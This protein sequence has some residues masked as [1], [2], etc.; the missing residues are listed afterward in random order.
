MRLPSPLTFFISLL[1]AFAACFIV[2]GILYNIPAVNDRLYPRVDKWLNDARELVAPAPQT[3]PTAA[4]VANLPTFAPDTPLPPPTLIPTSDYSTTRPPDYLTTRLPDYPTNTPIP[5]IFDLPANVNLPGARYEPQLYNNCG[6]ATLTAALV[7]WGWRGVEPDE[8]VWYAGG[9]DIRW[10]RDIAKVIKPGKSD[11][12]VMPYELTNFAAE[13]AGLNAALRYGG[14]IDRIRRFVANGFPVIIER[15]FREEEH[16]QVGQG[17]EGHYSVVTGYND[18]TR[19]LLT[20]DSF[21]G[22]NY[23]RD[24]DAMTRDWRDF[25]YLYF[26]LY[27]PDRAAQVMAL[28]GPDADAGANLNRALVKAQTQ[29][30]QNTELADLAFDWFNVGTSLQLL[31]RNTDAAIAFDQARSYDKLPYRMVW[32]QT[33]M[34]KAYFY[35]NR[36]QE[37][38]DLATVALQTPGLEESYYWRGWAY[39]ELGNLDAAI[40]DMRAAL[41]AHPKWDQALNA[42]REWGINP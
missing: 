30:S 31:G 8:L 28:L 7:Y 35:T 34:Y 17:W 10:Q 9:V 33:Y 21:K 18:T 32:Y 40:A 24:Y 13:Y 42:L 11:K 6:P 27:P 14:D 15:A 41:D 12:N 29:A 37:V 4:P 20:Q 5:L 3:L 39:H 36:Y 1:A 22:P 19:Q 25:N 16:G 26:I 38:I 23:L 2:S